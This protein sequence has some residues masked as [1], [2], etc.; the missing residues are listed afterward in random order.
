MLARTGAKGEPMAS[1]S[2]WLENLRLK[3]KW[4]CDVVKMKSFLS[5]FLVRF[6]LGLW[7]KMIFI[8]MPMVSWSGR[9]V[10]RL[11]TL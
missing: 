11:V 6:R 2:I 3:I 5:S 10:K 7:L 8:A 4:V 9:L 1:P